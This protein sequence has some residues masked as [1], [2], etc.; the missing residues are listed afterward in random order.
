MQDRIIPHLDSQGATVSDKNSW[1]TST[2]LFFHFMPVSSSSQ[3]CLSQLTHQILYTNIGRVRRQQSV[4][5]ILT[6]TVALHK[7]FNVKVLKNLVPQNF[8][9][10]L[11]YTSG[12]VFRYNKFDEWFV[13]FR[14]VMTDT[15]RTDQNSQ[16]WST[17]LLAHNATQHHW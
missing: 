4:S 11:K 3:C 10:L 14:L 13:D 16:A 9:S 6:E 8:N 17:V 15:C 12:R 7:Y 5:A 1:D 2:T